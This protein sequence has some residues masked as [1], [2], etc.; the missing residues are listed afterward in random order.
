[1]TARSALAAGAPEGLRARK[2]RES[3]EQLFQ[4]AIS[5]F[6]QRGFQATRVEDVAA[7]AHTSLKTFFNYFPSKRAVLDEYACRLLDEFDARLRAAIADESTTV[8]R[9][10]RELLEDMGRAVEGDRRL[11]HIVFRESKLFCADAAMRER[12]MVT[13]RL[14]AD[15]IHRGQARSELR[16]DVDALQAAEL[17]FGLYYFTTANWLARW[18]PSRPPLAR[19]LH[20]GALALLHGLAM[21]R[22][23]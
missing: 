17:L 7:R 12:E 8:P 4:A 9:R 13:Y 5:L 16:G 10:I 6:R 14:L 19:R 11:A 2:K 23:G 15:L 3:R 22:S 1:M 21:P 18:W 20:A